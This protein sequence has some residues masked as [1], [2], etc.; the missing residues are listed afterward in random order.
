MKQ[1]YILTNNQEEELRFVLTRVISNLDIINDFID[2]EIKDE[3]LKN[4]IDIVLKRIESYCEKME[5]ILEI[6]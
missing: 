3:N 6:E 2:D 4:A 5:E 1:V